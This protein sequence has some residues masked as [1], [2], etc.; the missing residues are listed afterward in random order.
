MKRHVT[1]LLTECL[2]AHYPF[3]EDEYI[4]KDISENQQDLAPLGLQLPEIK[5]INNRKGVYFPG[6]NHG[7]SYLKLPRHL[8]TG[9]NDE[10]G[11]TVSTWVYLER[12]ENMWERIFDFGHGPA[13]PYLFMTRHFRS[14]CF[15]GQDLVADASHTFPENEWLHVVLSIHPTRRGKES[16]AGPIVYVNGEC[17]ADGLISQTSSGTYKALREWFDTLEQTNMY[18]EN[19]IGKSQ[20]FADRDFH[21]AIS[22]FRLYDKALSHDEVLDLLCESLSDEKIVALATDHYLKRPHPIVQTNLN[23]PTT[24]M[25]DKVSVEWLSS[26]SDVLSHAGIIVEA[27]KPTTVTLTAKVTCGDVTIEKP[28]LVTILPKSKPT[29]ELVI[30]ASQ[31]GLNI[32]PHMYG[33]FYEDINN[34]ADGGI[35]AEYVQ[36][37]SFESFVF[38]TYDQQSGSCGC[39]TGRNHAPLHMWF[40]DLDQV[41]VETV[42]GLNASFG[43]E[44]S[45]VNQHYVTIEKGATLI[46]KGFTDNNQAPRMAF[47]QGHHYD[48]TV[49]AKA[50]ETAE[51]DIQLRDSQG[52]LVSETETLTVIDGGQWRKYHMTLTANQ[53]CFGELALTAQ[54]TLALDFIS[55]IPRDV[56]GQSEEEGSSSAH[57][58]YLANPNYRLRKDLVLALKDLNPAFLRF[59]GGCISEGSY[60]WD[61]V[62]EWKDSIGPVE[63]RKENF[64]VW[65]YMMTMGLGYMEYF[66][67]AEDLNATPLPVMACGV[68][69]QA[70]SDYVNP[71]GGKLRDHFVK[72]FTDLIDFALSTDVETNPWAKIRSEMGHPAPFDLRYLGIGNENWGTELYANFAYFKTRIDDYMETHYPERALTIVSTVGAQA[73]DEAF[74]EGWKYLSGKMETNQNVTFTDGEKAITETVDWYQDQPHFM[75]TIA[76][77]H[78]Y[79]SNDYLLN[80]VDR[81]DYYERRYDKTGEL[82]EAETSKVFVGEFA[83]TD[84]N[85]LMGAISEAATMTG[86]EN[87]ADVVRLVAYAPLFNKVLT[88]QTY[89]WTPDLIWFDDASVWFTPNYYVQ[90]LFG[91]SV[92]KEVL[93][94]RLKTYEKDTLTTRRPKGGI[95]LSTSEATIL[96]K[97]V[98]VKKIDS[99]EVLLHQDFTAPL[100]NRF[101]LI[102]GSEAFTK[103]TAGIIFEGRT[104]GRNGLYLLAPDW[105]DY[106]VTC[107]AQKIAG[108]AGLYVGVGLK[109]I[110]PED[111]TVIEYAILSDGRYDGIKV[112]KHGKEGYTLGDYSSSTLAGNLRRG[113]EGAFKQGIDYTIHVVFSDQ[114]R[115]LRCQYSNKEERSDTLTYK[116]EAYHNDLFTSVTTDEKIVYVK[117]VNAEGY[118]KSV[119]LTFEALD[120]HDHVE[121]VTITGDEADLHVPN[122]NT[123]NNEVITPVTN[124]INVTEAGS[125]TVPKYSVVVVKL[126]RK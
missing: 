61:N 74:Q 60:I 56:W 109:S 11:L 114:D 108:E 105:T 28:Y 84:K 38:D 13:G 102:P 14:V 4:G 15:N 32:A 12:G 96:L 115:Q 91:H 88:D 8:L 126:M 40:G 42:G 111:K 63:T 45:D 34:A 2:L 59:P 49:W 39:S 50:N 30:D 6:G 89:R 27:E 85:T 70:R 47:K 81:Y 64:N 82:N 44:D 80:N 62:Y 9:I 53:T 119:A 29:H 65:G 23:L 116:L 41:K 26:D 5:T 106:E 43:I 67:L 3:D 37:R 66:Q 19:F 57:Q 107:V 31:T 110:A 18:T 21:G 104:S 72:S 35:Y 98:T 93:P 83:S 54:D 87:N 20:F 99:D 33:L 10:T 125:V 24:L 68:L 118:D 94:T 122:I 76:D 22:D 16:S 100:D 77:E 103:T 75:D 36:N 48:F 52:V 7:T 86:Y 25:G 55:L 73:D 101:A 97:S 79:R 71:A 69:C 120:V 92:G 46:N 123:K 117:L 58:N 112:F 124:T 90:Q 51:L 1:P 113:Y 78:Y 95:S 17:V 121:V